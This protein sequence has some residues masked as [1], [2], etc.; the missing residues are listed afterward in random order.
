ME[1]AKSRATYYIPGYNF[2]LLLAMQ[3]GATTLP[4]QPGALP[5]QSGAL[6]D[7]S[8]ALSGEVPEHIKGML[9]EVGRRTSDKEKMNMAIITL[10]QWRPLTLKQL[11]QYVQRNEKYLLENFITPLREAGKLLYTIPDMPNH[12]EQAYR[13]EARDKSA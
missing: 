13:S 8:D 4:D 3:Q 9:M 5:D 7:Q 6:S 10:C 12:P 2:S 11:A 1:T